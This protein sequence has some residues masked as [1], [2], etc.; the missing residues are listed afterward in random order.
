[1]SPVIFSLTSVVNLL[2]VEMRILSEDFINDRIVLSQTTESVFLLDKIK[3]DCFVPVE[4]ANF[5]EKS[6]VHFRAEHFEP[7]ED[8]TNS[9]VRMAFDDFIVHFV[10]SF[11]V[12]FFIM[13]FEKFALSIVLF[14]G[15]E[16]GSELDSIVTISDEFE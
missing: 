3:A 6:L 8:E 1:M 5:T 12:H 10:K 15:A 9:E 14:Q 13:F 16:K 7:K 11:E 4:V 2:V